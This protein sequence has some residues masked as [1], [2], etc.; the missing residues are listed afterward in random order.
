MMFKSFLFVSLLLV[1]VVCQE[2]EQGDASEL[3]APVERKVRNYF[4][5]V[6]SPFIVHIVID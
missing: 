1:L 2:E 4:L 5:W 6:V 3:E